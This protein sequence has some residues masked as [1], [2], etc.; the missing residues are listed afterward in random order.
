MRQWLRRR[1]VSA[2][3]FD[4][5]SDSQLP[6]RVRAAVLRQQE[7][8][9]IAIGWVQLAVVSAF[10]TLYALAPKTFA[11]DT[12]APVPWA[13]GGYFLFTVLR[14]LL[15]HQRRLNDFMLYLSIVF[16]MGLLLGL[17]W[18]F[19]L[20]YEQPPSFYLK[21][22]TLLYAFIFIALRAL[23][24]EARFVLAAGFT[25]A[26]GWGAM[27]WYAMG[28]MSL[29]DPITRDYVEYMTSN[30]ILLGAEF[31]KIISILV[32]TGILAYGVDRA[33]RLL[34]HGVAEA[35]TAQQLARFVPSEV[36]ALVAGS[37]DGVTPGQGEVQEATILFTDIES[38]TGI[39]ERRAPRALIA[40]LNEYF[41]LVAEPIHRR[42]GVISQFQ[43]DAILA[44][45][46]A[47]RPDAQHAEHAVLAALDI[48]R[49]LDGRTFGDGIVF[50]TRVGINSGEVVG[51]LV[52][53]GERVSYTVHGDDV[54][55]AARL[56]ALNKEYGTRVI[57]SESTR[58]RIDDTQ[59]EFRRLGEV[60]VRGR[61]QPLVIYTIG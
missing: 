17:I 21:A 38:F 14:L 32:V 27:M 40:A 30:R 44:T 10:A 9:E 24:F 25:A 58:A 43:G 39:A 42:G 22:P 18:S 4:R 28:D 13:L 41:A 61:R 12:F 57:V 6:A 33:R 20:Q 23:H 8:S 59:L 53:S 55:L 2:G 51:G 36:A 48:Q 54:N 45:F 29:A 49:L 3:L 26:A 37:E 46:N 19:H 11:D 5:L 50:N 1:N 15:A 34:E 60:E 7:S 56:E 47:P 35:Q 16:D 31:D 52:G